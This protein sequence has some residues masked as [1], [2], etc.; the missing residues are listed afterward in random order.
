MQTSKTEDTNILNIYNKMKI[1]D[2]RV[3]GKKKSMLCFIFLNP[4]LVNL[5]PPHYL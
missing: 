5:G 3:V 1:G 2:S 4:S